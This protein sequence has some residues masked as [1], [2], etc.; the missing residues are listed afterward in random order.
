MF[1]EAIVTM[2]RG[3]EMLTSAESSKRGAT[4]TGRGQSS[5]RTPPGSG[6]ANTTVAAV[7]S[8]ASGMA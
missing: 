2:N 7:T 8:T 4:K 6:V 3:T 5:A 1:C